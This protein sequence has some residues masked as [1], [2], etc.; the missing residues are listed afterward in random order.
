MCVCVCVRV[1]V[2]VCACM[3]MC[4]FECVC[5]CVYAC[6]CVN[7]ITVQVF[8]AWRCITLATADGDC[9]MS[10]DEEEDTAA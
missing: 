9:N 2:G 4:L 8:N 1:W 3:Y 5:V 10:L 7:H 6:V